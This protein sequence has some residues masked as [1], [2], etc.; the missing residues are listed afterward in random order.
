MGQDATVL[1]LERTEFPPVGGVVLLDKTHER[2][3][4]FSKNVNSLA[5]WN[6]WARKLIDRGCRVVCFVGDVK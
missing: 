6:T 5:G 2:A 1:F 4:M 3:T